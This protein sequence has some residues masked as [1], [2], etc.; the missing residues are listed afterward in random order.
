MSELQ[1]TE[2]ELHDFA[3]QRERWLGALAIDDEEGKTLYM[4]RINQILDNYN[5]VNELLNAA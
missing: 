1:P 4:H 2:D 3:K 5:M